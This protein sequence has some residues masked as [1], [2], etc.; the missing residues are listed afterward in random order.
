[1][2][3]VASVGAD[4]FAPGCPKWWPGSKGGLGGRSKALGVAQSWRGL[5]SQQR[6]GSV[7]AS[8]STAAAGGG[9][10]RAVRTYGAPYPD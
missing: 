10:P 5:G 3:E 1:V 2:P 6:V 4:S 9:M 8:P 7:P